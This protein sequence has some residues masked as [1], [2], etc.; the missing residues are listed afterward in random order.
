MQTFDITQSKEQKALQ[1]KRILIVDADVKSR[2]V[3]ALILRKLGATVEELSNGKDAYEFLQETT[4]RKKDEIALMLMGI[5]M[6]QM[7]GINLLRMIRDHNLLKEL[8][9]FVMHSAHEDRELHECRCLGVTADIAKPVNI[10]EAVSTIAEKISKLKKLKKNKKET[11]PTLT[12]WINY[13]D[14]GFPIEYQNIATRDSYPLRASFYRCPFCDM[15]FTAP[16]L[17][18]KSLDPDLSDQLAIGLY[19][20][21]TAE[22]EHVVPLL[23]DVICCP[24]CL[25]AADREGFLRIWNR[26]NAKLHEIEK[27]PSNRWEYPIFSITPKLR[28][29]FTLFKRKRLDYVQKIKDLGEALFTIS[30]VD[31][32]FPRSFSDTQISID[33]ALYCN[34]FV[35]KNS[36]QSNHS[37]LCHKGAEYYFKKQYISGMMLER[38]RKQDDKKTLFASRLNSIIKSMELLLKVVDTELPNLQ[39]RCLFLRQ[40]FFLANMLS[41]ILRHPDQKLRIIE[42]KEDALQR[43]NQLLANAENMNNNIEAAIINKQLEPIINHLNLNNFNLPS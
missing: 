34:E 42:H 35:M 22:Y 4:Y 37:I 16:K 6:P 11:T 3:L 25:W 14:S 32:K 10:A 17:K 36:N 2:N 13:S 7:S 19:S 38:L 29:E 5:S 30:K 9:V 18:E 28:N 21:G 12:K 26:D 15:T 41:N 33:L 31:R 24:D 23:I 40:K 27:V 39:R 43:L 8:P 1:N 20:A